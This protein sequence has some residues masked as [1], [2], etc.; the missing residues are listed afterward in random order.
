ASPLRDLVR[1]IVGGNDSVEVRLALRHEQGIRYVF[2][3]AGLAS[4][5]VPLSADPAMAAALRGERGFLDGARHRGRT[6]VAMHGPVGH[7]DWGLV[8]QLDADEAYA[9]SGDLL[10]RMILT[11]LLLCALA[12]VVGLRL[13]AGFVRPIRELSD[14]ALA[15]ERGEFTTRARPTTSDEIGMLGHAFNHM[16][17]ALEAFS[18][19]MNERIAERTGD[20]ERSREQLRAAKERAEQASSAKT[21]FLAS[22][23]HEIRTPL[24]GILGM[25]EIMLQS[26][27]DPE[28]RR[29]AQVVHDSGRLLLRLLNDILDLTKVEAGKLELQDRDFSIRGL[30]SATMQSFE[31]SA[32]EKG[33]E[34]GCVVASDSPDLVRGDADRLR[35]ILT[36]LVGNAIK[37]TPAGSVK[38]GIRV[39]PKGSSYRLTATVRDTGIG[40]AADQQALVFERFHQVENPKVQAQAGTGLGLTI[41][42]RLAE[43]MGGRLS[44]ESE[45][46]RGSTFTFEVELARPAGDIDAHAAI[47][48]VGPPGPSCTVLLAEDGAVNRQVAGAMLEL[49]GHRVLIASNGVEALAMLDRHAV[50]LVLMDVLMPEMDGFEATRR[51]RE[52]EQGREQ[53]LPIIGLSAHALQGF[54]DRCLEAGMDDFIT[55]P[56]SIGAL[57][58]VIEHWLP[59]RPRS[60]ADESGA[61]PE[62]RPESASTTVASE[63]R[64]IALQRVGGNEATLRLIVQKFAEEAP[65]LLEVLGRAFETGAAG[66][67]ERAAHTLKGAADVLALEALVGLAYG[68]ERHGRAGD[69]EAA[70]RALPELEQAVHAALVEVAGW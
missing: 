6:V 46:G 12:M 16:A 26:P 70:G 27:L 37:F 30:A 52:G 23:S 31:P 36:N 60:P 39:A 66:E 53:H 68:V 58:R 34:L 7:A 17:R 55:K 22:M 11:G 13:A 62:S 20:I 14:A 48:R 10:R 28:Q 18:I 50:D 51:I 41:S 1:A 33:L 42:L 9:P 2:P 56:I 40:I 24:N 44:F 15:I 19:A 35:Q 38:V 49:R 67:C 45:P 61:E 21:R 64:R 3:V 54:R 65:R 5:D 57:D 8:V 29:R 63:V 59:D 43:R 4:Q 47:D 69:L 25:T 32:L